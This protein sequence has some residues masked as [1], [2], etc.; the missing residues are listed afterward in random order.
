MKG[1]LSIEKK[2]PMADAL[3]YATA[4]LHHA[5]VYTQNQHFEGLVQ[6]SEV[7]S[8]GERWR[9][10]LNGQPTAGGSGG[11]AVKPLP[12]PHPASPRRFHATAETGRK[13]L[14][15]H[16]LGHQC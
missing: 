16:G 9:H 13:G 3:F 11:L 5:T 2:L 7:L 8:K 15:D 14:R 4:L 6:V 1:K 12:S 10:A